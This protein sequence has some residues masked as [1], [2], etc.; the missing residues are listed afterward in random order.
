MAQLFR[1]TPARH[2]SRRWMS[3]AAE[4]T[5]LTISKLDKVG[6]LT[7]TRPRALNALNS[8]VLHDLTVVSNNYD[9]GRRVT[10]KPTSAC[11][12]IGPCPW[13]GVLAE[14]SAEAH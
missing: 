5:L 4:E 7:V 3:V 8:Q 11:V 14:L 9:Y 10:S 6:V 2:H 13:S 1:T 12:V